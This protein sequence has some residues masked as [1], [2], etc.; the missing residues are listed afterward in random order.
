MEGN[1]FQCPCPVN[2]M[3]RGAWWATAHGVTESQTRLSHKTTTTSTMGSSES[4]PRDTPERNR[5]TCPQINLYTDVHSGT[6][7][8]STHTREHDAAT[9]RS[10]ALTPATT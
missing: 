6:I 2:A 7:Q 3:D 5:N 4:T 10:R 1:P 9:K 8:V